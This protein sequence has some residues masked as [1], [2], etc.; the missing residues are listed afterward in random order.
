MTKKLLILSWPSGSWKDT[1]KKFI[2]NDLQYKNL[3]STTTR[4]KRIWEIDGINYNFISNEQ[5][6]QLIKN[7]EILEYAEFNN[8]YYGKQKKDLYKLIDN[9]DNIVTILETKGIKNIIKNQNLFINNNYEIIIVY[10]DIN[11]ETIKER[12]IIRGDDISKINQR[13]ENNDYE[14]FQE[15]KNNYANLIID[16]NNSSPDH[17]FNELLQFLTK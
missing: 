13:L 3:I 5:F 4:E 11:K 8:S 9:N 6:N 10:L 7:W 14:Y 1:I 12:M 2:E 17:V 16:T 15:I